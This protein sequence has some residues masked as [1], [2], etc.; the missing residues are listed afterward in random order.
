MSGNQIFYTMLIISSV[1]GL[2]AGMIG[3][4]LGYKWGYA[5]AKREK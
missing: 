1:L 4:H 5:T 2:V 3:L